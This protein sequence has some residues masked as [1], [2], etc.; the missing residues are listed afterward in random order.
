M[1]TAVSDHGYRHLPLRQP[2]LP[3][4]AE[5]KAWQAGLFDFRQNAFRLF[6]AEGAHRLGLDVA[7]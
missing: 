2:P 1:P 6:A 5:T 3:A 7:Q 4:F